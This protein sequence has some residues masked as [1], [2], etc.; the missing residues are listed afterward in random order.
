MPNQAIRFTTH[1]TLIPGQAHIIQQQQLF[2]STPEIRDVYA[3]NL[4]QAMDELIELIDDYPF[5]AMDTEFPGVV[6]RPVGNFKS[7]SDYTYQTLRCNV[8]LLRIIQL[9]ITL[10][11]EHG[12]RPPNVHTYQFN[13]YF[14]MEQ[15]MH[16]QD[17]IDL[18]AKSGI[19]F[20]KLARGGV[21]VDEF[22]ERLVSSG[23]VL[24]PKIRWISFHSAYDFGYLLKL[25]TCDALPVEETA[26][27]SQLRIFFPVIFDIKYM[28][29]SCRGLKGGLQDVA[30]EVGV[31]RIGPQHQA[32]S[33]ALLTS[34]TF[35][36]LRSI[37]F[38]GEVDTE[39]FGHCLFGL[40]TPQEVDAKT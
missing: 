2:S 9:G 33:D 4:H 1:P 22:G 12:R 25:L 31:E 26:F 23:L 19:D 38:G 39:R 7:A 27:Q 11:D 14:N 37:Y 20:A 8:D 40:S 30:D 21:P 5:I 13:F 15:D 18:L 3:D 16:A 36:K 10:S 17:S 34:E 29:K 6:A 32:G 35:F 24:N 28:M